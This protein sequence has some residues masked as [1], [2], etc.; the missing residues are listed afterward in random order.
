MRSGSLKL[1]CV[2][3]AL[4]G[5]LWAA[6]MFAAPETGTPRAAAPSA[7]LTRPKDESN[8]TFYSGFS[9]ALLLNESNA[10]PQ[11]SA[12]IRIPNKKTGYVVALWVPLEWESATTVNGYYGQV[13]RPLNVDPTEYDLGRIFVSEQS[14][15]LSSLY[16]IFTFRFGAWLLADQTRR[17]PFASAGVGGPQNEPTGY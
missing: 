1:L 3:L 10:N 15:G 9:T 5:A 2:A 11:A 6:T 17:T 12:I 7:P 16:P 13:F 4:G 8:T 14:Y